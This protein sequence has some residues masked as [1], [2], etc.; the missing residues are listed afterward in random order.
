MPSEQDDRLN[1]LLGN[2]GSIA[3]RSKIARELDDD[4]LQMAAPYS[5]QAKE[6]L[7]RRRHEQLL[8]GR[9]PT[10][11]TRELEQ[12]FQ[13]LFSPRQMHP[14]FDFWRSEAGELTGYS[15]GVIFLDID[16]FKQF[17][18]NFTESVVD[19]TIFA[20]LQRL[21]AGLCLQ[22]G[23]AYRYGGEELILLLPNSSLDETAAFAHKVCRQIAANAFHV[24]EQVV[25][26]TVSIGVA[27]WPLHGDTLQI[28]IERANQEER[29]AKEQGKNRVS[30][31]TD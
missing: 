5:R 27:A 16:N 28:V 15:V 30:V 12:K 18:T 20:D 1:K 13:I 7:E 8:E 17:N 19:K 26:M 31:A 25:K 11:T 22:R 10:I 21:V 3:E 2:R 9:Q 23:A 4:A 14:D 6:E 29:V 24:Q